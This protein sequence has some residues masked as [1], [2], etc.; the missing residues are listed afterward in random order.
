L[1]PKLREPPCQRIGLAF[2]QVEA[3]KAV[4]TI[5]L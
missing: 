4:A 2:V 3:Q 5:L 1:Q